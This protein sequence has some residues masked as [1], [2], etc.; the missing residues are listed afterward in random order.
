MATAGRKPLLE[1]DPELHGRIMNY[2]RAGAF[3]E[4]AAVAAGVSERSHYAWQDKGL[5][6]RDRREAGTK[7]RSTWDIYVK[8]VDGIDQATAE[9]E[10]LLLAKVNNGGQGWSAQLAILERRFRERWGVKPTAAGGSGKPDA[11]PAT[12]LDEFSKR[13]AER[14]GTATSS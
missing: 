11:T 7:P 3:P 10:M 12:G 1:T 6:E 4:R 13:R 8:Y 9:A 5:E 2:I 14:R